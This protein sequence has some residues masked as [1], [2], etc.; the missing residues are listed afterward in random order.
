MIRRTTTRRRPPSASRRAERRQAAL[1]TIARLDDDGQ[2]I[3][4]RRQHPP[5]GLPPGYAL[6]IMAAGRLVPVDLQ[7]V[8]ASCPGELAAVLCRVLGPATGWA[9]WRG[10]ADAENPPLIP[11][12]DTAQ[13][14]LWL[15]AG[16]ATA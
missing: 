12:G 9:G 11:L 15:T 4:T 16:R 3:V 7:P 1:R 6:V 13:A 8:T 5:A 10:P 14:V 2:T